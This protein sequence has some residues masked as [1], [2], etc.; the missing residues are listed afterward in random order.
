MAL[1][2]GDIIFNIVDVKLDQIAHVLRS[3]L[4]V[5]SKRATISIQ[6]LVI[7]SD[8]EVRPQRFE[9]IAQ[10]LENGTKLFDAICYFS[11]PADQRPEISVPVEGQ[12]P[13][14]RDPVEISRAFFY[15]CFLV[16][17]RGSPSVSNDST[18]GSSV[19][20]FLARILALNR[21]PAFYA[22]RLAGFPIINLD[23]R[24]VSHFDY[25]DIGQEALNRFGLG[26][27]GYRLLNPFKLYVPKDNITA[28]QRV[29]YN[30]LRGIATR[31]ADWSIHPV[32]RDTAII[33]EFGSINNNAGNLILDI[34]TNA[35]IENMIATKV[36]YKYPIRDPKSTQYLTWND[37]TRINLARPIFHDRQL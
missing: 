30:F 23:W 22:D 4:I 15:Q 17:T 20:A 9:N 8:K 16:L 12:L 37:T 2:L 26:V 3:F 14:T 1:P 33:Q 18:I 32:T 5:G 35:Q 27:A 36:L 7:I 29:A 6:S 31:P 21:A 25:N 11:L 10:A 13:D 34:Y 24:F 19:P 28:Q